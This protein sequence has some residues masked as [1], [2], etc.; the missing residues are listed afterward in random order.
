MK[1]CKPLL[2]EDAAKY[3]RLV[4][5]NLL[6]PVVNQ[7][8]GG[9]KLTTL[10][11]KPYLIN[12]NGEHHQRLRVLYCLIYKDNLEADQHVIELKDGSLELLRDE[13]AKLTG[14]ARKHL[15]PNFTGEPLSGIQW[16][17]R[18]KTGIL[19]S[20]AV[21]TWLVT[22][23]G[24]YGGSFKTYQEACDRRLDMMNYIGPLPAL[25]TGA[26]A[27]PVDHGYIRAKPLGAV[28]HKYKRWVTFY[29]DK[30]LYRVH[31]CGKTVLLTLHEHQAFAKA[32]ELRDAA[33]F[34]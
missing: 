17:S 31:S 12:V 30:Q 27:S 29:A 24:E 4:G 13:P 26:Y 3:Y 14:Y 10:A 5:A 28:P 19:T 11:K 16:R 8:K 25:S 1:P 20:G 32:K 33:N 18:G 23:K 9:S 22:Y 2:Y 21:G 6:T 34:N 7:P 15:P